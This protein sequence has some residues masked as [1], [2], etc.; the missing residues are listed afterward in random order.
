MMI[1]SK[2]FCPYCM[3]TKK[4]FS[5]LGVSPTVLELD[6]HGDG[7]EMQSALQSLTGQ[8]TVPNVFINGTHVGGNDDTQRA[9]QSGELDKL[10][11]A[12]RKNEKTHQK[13]K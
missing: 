1:F 2:S 3:Q 11:S 12:A 4:L 10:L 9:V 8:R 5:D 6:I 13:N 7:F